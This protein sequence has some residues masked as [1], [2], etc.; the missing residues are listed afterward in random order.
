MPDFKLISADGHIVEPPQAW[1][2][3]QKEYGARAPKV[4]KN[5]PDVSEGTWIMS[6]GLPPIGMSHFCAGMVIDKPDGVSN[7][8]V[9]QFQK[10]QKFHEEFQ[11]EN[12][13]EGWDPAARVRAQER[14]GLEAEILY[15]SSTQAFYGLTEPGVQQAI[16]RSYNLW[17]HEFCRYDPTRLVGVPVLSIL[18]VEKAVADIHEYAAMGFKV[19]LIPTG[20]KDSGYYELFYEPL[21]QAAAETGLVLSVHTNTIQGMVRTRFGG[22]R[23]DG[24]RTAPLS[25]R[26]DTQVGAE[27]FMGNLIFSG[28]LDRYPDLKLVCAEFDVGWVGHLY[29][30]VDYLVGNAAEREGSIHKLQ[31][32]DYLNHNFFFTFQDDRSGI[33][34]TPVYG[35]NNYLWANDFPHLVTTWPY[36]RQTVDRNFEGIDPAVMRKICRANAAELY[37]LDLSNHSSVAAKSAA[38]GSVR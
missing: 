12:Y 38:A 22:P 6:D 31:P 28:V 16:F 32:T 7:V 1:N 17:L 33:L 13:P 18:E 14:D 30:Q 10:R 37:C 11:W 2:R 8:D 29:Q 23:P 34:T 35:V 9:E 21:W 19:A 15:P 36:S 5:P 20:I 25:A 26:T 4:V 24:P 27:K 3:V